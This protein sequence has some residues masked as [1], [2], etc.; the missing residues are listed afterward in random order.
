MESTYRS[1]L[2]DRASRRYA[3]PSEDVWKLREAASVLVAFDPATLQPNGDIS[4]ADARVELLADCDQSGPADQPA[5]WQLRTPIRQVTLRRLLAAGGVEAA[6]S[7]NSRPA[8]ESQQLL[9]SVLTGKRLPAWEYAPAERQRALL[10]VIEWVGG[11]ADLRGRLPPVE[12]I[13]ERLAWQQLLQPFRDLIGPS[14]AG[15]RMELGQ[16]S[17]YVGVADAT[18]TSESVKRAVETFFS[19]KERPPLFIYGPGGAGK[20]TLIARFILDHADRE[21]LRIPFAYLDFDRPGLVAEEPITLLTEIIRQLGLQYPTHQSRGRELSEQWAA[22]ASEQV[23]ATVNAVGAPPPRFRL[24]NRD[25]FLSEFAAFVG[26]LAV[27][28]QPLLLVLDTFEEVQFRSGVFAEEVLDFLN[29][30]Q[31]QLPRLRT[32]LSGRSEIVSPKYSMRTVTLGNF[33]REAA[34]AFLEG[35]GIDDP[36]VAA[37]VFDQVGGS[38][39]VLRLAADVAHLENVTAEGIGGL[40]RWWSTF[41]TQS[42]EVVLYKRIL[43]HVYDARVKELAYPGLIL[44]IITPDVLQRVLA[45]SCAVPIASPADAAA[46][47]SVMRQQLSTI[48]TT[49]ADRETLVHRPDIRAILLKDLAERSGKDRKVADTLRKINDAA[50][51]YYSAFDDPARRAEELYHR[52]AL[53]VDRA[54]LASRWMAGLTPFLGSSIKELP[55]K[56]QVYLAARL[57]LE[58]TDAAWAEAEDEDWVLYALRTINQKLELRRPAD[59]LPIVAARPHLFDKNEQIAA[60]LERVAFEIFHGFAREY[61]RIRGSQPA[62][63]ARTGNM[64]KLVSGLV[65]NAGSLPPDASYVPSLLEEGTPGT[66]VAAI[67][68]ALAHA[69]AGGMDL[70]IDMIRDARSPFEQYH[71]LRLA[72]TRLASSTPAQR[73][74]LRDSLIHQKGV[75]IDDAETDLSRARLKSEILKLIDAAS[76]RAATSSGE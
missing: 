1:R 76:T 2:Q 15:R 21:T 41:W 56:S 19:I 8:T 50:I 43:S 57:G 38:P 11:V 30:L 63:A 5:L 74:A 34:I 3:G 22:R 6:L 49:G 72:R 32:V 9:E 52:L 18:T 20:S 31:S 13:K 14:F 40:P 70:A 59:I 17:D 48:L 60:A 61:E 28:D 27:V 73:E 45:E 44:R 62:G 64:E 69:D 29:L 66:R 54:M 67:A 7:R 58:L 68:V 36:S 10:E 71:A 53:G 75:V 37:R 55:I 42:I 39:L 33:D 47:I 46:L 12:A 26:D 16:L 24:Q 4:S 35:R 25:A 51:G 23:K 65:S